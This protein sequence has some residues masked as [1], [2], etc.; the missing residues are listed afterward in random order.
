MVSPFPTWLWSVSCFL[1]SVSWGVSSACPLGTWFLGSAPLGTPLD[2]GD[3]RARI[4]LSA[5]PEVPASGIYISWGWVLCPAC[6]T[7]TQEGILEMFWSLQLQPIP[8]GNVRGTKQA[9]PCSNQPGHVLG[10]Q[11]LRG[12]DGGSSRNPHAGLFGKKA[13]AQPL[14]SQP[15][16]RPREAPWTYFCDFQDITHVVLREH[17]ISIHCQDKCL[18]GPK[19]GCWAESWAGGHPQPVMPA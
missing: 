8:M 16:D 11:G 12:G 18:V 14:S 4:L 2:L 15:V 10:F 19:T 5:L 3:E 1:G 6:D 17:H 13:K 9:Q 7:M